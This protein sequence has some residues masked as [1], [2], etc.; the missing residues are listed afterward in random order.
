MIKRVL[1][2]ERETISIHHLSVLGTIA[3]F[4]KATV[5][6]SSLSARQAVRMEQ[7]YSNW[8]DFCEILYKNFSKICRENWDF[9]NIWLEY[10]TFRE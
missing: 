8:T 7:L 4:R 1:Y 6:T 3:K 5:G 10:R 2:S 9:I